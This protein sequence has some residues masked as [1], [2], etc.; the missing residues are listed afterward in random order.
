MKTDAP[1][2]TPDDLEVRITALL[3]GELSPPDEA[4][5]RAAMDRDPAL[6]R[7]QARLQA[8]IAL[9]REVEAQPVA[10]SPTQPATMKLSEAR[11][12]R[13]LQQFKTVRAHDLLPE[14]TPSKWNLQR[15]LLPLGLAAVL[16]VVASLAIPNFAKARAKSM[17]ASSY[18]VAPAAAAPLESR[19]AI[20]KPT[21]RTRFEG[22][23]TDGRSAGLPA[24]AEAAAPTQA[25]RGPQP[26]YLPATEAG[27]AGVGGMR[28]GGTVENY[29]EATESARE[30]ASNRG[31]VG[32]RSEDRNSLELARGYG[33]MG[34]GG[35]AGFGGGGAVGPRDSSS[36]FW[37]TAGSAVGGAAG[38]P[39]GT[40][41]QQWFFKQ[42]AAQSDPGVVATN[43]I[44]ANASDFFFAHSASDKFGAVALN[45]AFAANRPAG[46]TGG[47]ATGPASGQEGG[48][49]SRKDYD[50][51]GTLDLVATRGANAGPT[52]GQK[53]DDALWGDYANDG[54]ARRFALGD[55]PTL[56]RLFKNNGD[57]KS[58]AAA[59]RFESELRVPLAVAGNEFA[60]T[61]AKQ[62]QTAVEVAPA[63]EPLDV[64]L[65]APALAVVPVDV[66]IVLAAQAP[67]TA[68][69]A[70]MQPPAAAAPAPAPAGAAVSSL[71]LAGLTA[72]SQKGQQLAL[73][74]VVES[75]GRPLAPAEPDS[76]ALGYGLVK[77]E[78]W[79][80]PAA[81]AGKPVTRERLT[82]GEARA[83]SVETEAKAK[84]DVLR[85]SAPAATA[86][87]ESK[88]G[89]GDVRRSLA[90][91]DDLALGV[92]LKPAEFEAGDDSARA[93]K[94]TSSV[95]V[96][97]PADPALRQKVE[98][99]SAVE[100][101]QQLRDMAKLRVLQES[102]GS[103]A[104]QADVGLAKK[105]AATEQA[106]AEVQKEA[107]PA[108][109]VP[110]AAPVVQREEQVVARPIAPPPVPQPEVSTRQNPFS[111][112]SLNVSDVSFKL[113]ASSLENGTLPD[114]GS[115]RTEEFINAFDYHDPE[116]AP[117]VPIGFA[118][119]R[120][121]DPFAHNRDLIR[122]SLQTAARGRE[123]G[124]PL[125][126]VLLLDSS[127]SMERA[128]RV[129]IIREALKVLAGQ[130]KPED[131]IS[132]V[133]FART[134]RLWIDGLPGSQAAELVQRVGSLTPEGGTNLEDAMNLA[135]QTAARHYLANGV[136]RVVL[137]T[138][139]AANLGDVEPESLKQKVESNRK[140][141]IALDC[142]GIGWEGYNDDLLEVLSRNGDGRYGFVNSPEEA[143]TGFANQLAGALQVAASDVK[144]QVEFNPAR[145]TAYRQIGYAKHQLTKEQFR[146]N[147]VDAAEIGAAEAGNALYALEINP[148]GEGPIG[149]VRVRYKVPAT[150]EYREHEWEMAYQGEAPGLDRSSPAIRLAGTAAAFAEWLASSPFAAE[151]APDRLL[152]LM[153]G[154]P[155]SFGA[156][157]RPKKLEW[158]I[159]QAQ[160]IRGK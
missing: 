71:A 14:I 76:V 50:G 116:P 41:G 39:S 26:I 3:L 84:I 83:N 144:V 19:M 126:L 77:D 145:V 147:T 108:Q 151:I 98:L 67:A 148:A 121:H 152:G 118:W 21:G 31:A 115:I 107:A 42:A 127:G 4:E 51:D 95:S 9:V 29:A 157:P 60:E 125:N 85:R 75:Q 156:D 16:V 10:T 80:R 136:N 124:R 25:R 53:A 47:P 149:I 78:S 137:L 63:K 92:E 15:W 159:R 87:A 132:V 101:Q 89:A 141:G 18:A 81:V 104:R 153:S 48:G 131:T 72:D 23:A 6:A 154:V 70:P 59:G 160:S 44:A 49:L 24:V 135:Y 73:N 36:A 13:L 2:P 61:P 69:A 140:Q 138:D 86:S 37:D 57:V 30:V 100:N 109:S 12:Q 5:L 40:P 130:M 32:G 119:E 122:L 43:A 8:T 93:L 54:N 103:G 155:E 96:P 79:Q 123:A 82:E 91:L 27:D 143:A 52:V 114:P 150:G 46:E 58:S 128:D 134:A 113:A 139:G 33:G 105:L 56:G 64:E 65:P 110:A 62:V 117:G 88:P 112:F 20:Q 1:I 97:P 17:A 99:Q 120:A 28:A 74:Q 146:D 111:T 142:F 66:P 133:A 129:S 90:R 94:P 45:G 106:L 55:Q 158:M 22:L 35:G 34:G 38:Q 7:L 11:R 68:F 102:V